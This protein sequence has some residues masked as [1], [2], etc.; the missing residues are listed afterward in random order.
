MK[1]FLLVLALVLLSLTQVTAQPRR[2]ARQHVPID[3][4]F[5][6]DPCILAD[7][8]THMYYMTGTG[9]MLWRSADLQYWDGP[10]QVTAT[11]PDSWM[12]PRPMIWAAEL[13]AIDG[14]YYYFATF[15][16]REVMIDTVGGTPIERR[17]CHV[18]VSDKPDGPYSSMADPTYLP[19]TK[20]TLDGTYWRDSDGKPY[21]IFCHE[22][23]QNGNG[24]VE[25]IPLKDDLS[26]TIG[27]STILFRAH[28][29]PWSLEK[30]SDDTI[31]PNKVTDGPWL[32]RTD[33]G[34]LGM[35]WT[36][37]R[38]GEYTQGVAYSESGTLD[39]PW[40]HEKEPI[41]PPNFGHAMLFRTFEG[42]WLMS[43]HSH[44]KDANGRTIRKPCLFRVDLSGDKLLVS[45]QYHPGWT[46]ISNGEMW[47]DDQGK[48][49]QAHAAGFLH[50]GDTWYM[51]GE[52]RLRSWNPDVN[53][54][55]SKDLVHWHFES[56][57]IENGVT[58][59]ELGKTRF[60]ERAKLLRSPKTGKYV[61][62]CHWE[63]QGYRAS[64]AACFVADNITGPYRFVS[65][66]RPLNI[67]S[68]DCNVFVDDDGTAWFISTIEE[69]RH[70]GLFRLSDDYTKAEECTVLFRE[71]SREAPAI[72][73]VDD[74]YYMLSSA[75]TGWAPNQCKLSTTHTL[76]SGWTPLTNVGDSI[77]FD[78]QAASI[79]TIKGSKK[80]TYLYVGDRWM[81]PGLPESKTIIF[82]IDFHDGT[83]TFHPL[84][85]FE[86]NFET[87]EWRETS[88]TDIQT[89]KRAENMKQV[90]QFIKNCGHYFLATTEGQQPRVRPF[91]TV[92]IFDG[93]L[94]IQTGKVKN[95]A[96]QIARNPQVEICA[97]NGKE[98]IRVSGTLIEDDRREARKSMLDAY[99]ELRSMYSEDDGNTVVY[100]L[101]DATATISSFTA[102]EVKINF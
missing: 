12:G 66:E 2:F 19:A 96:H 6:S 60:I 67:K 58:H 81:D 62:W 27:E 92:N 76:T 83:C 31:G 93:K 15:T 98:W 25:K 48:D 41:T 16:N 52:D 55:S 69:N 88:G 30:Y 33:S 26:G 46:R 14:K 97:F 82:P 28:D 73:R 56:K 90:Y 50:E 47:T 61:V 37:W 57:I 77:A 11:D 64:E 65:G 13:H 32:F 18:L 40:V 21:L 45:E 3:S 72:V 79:L 89:I 68:R 70:L 59:P 4:I 84:D 51:I 5:L 23:L 7:S 34:R 75:C 9:G 99:P 38:F 49:V 29:S 36:S 78:T 80:T 85:A 91:G 42:E 102:P 53:M 44:A 24:T 94:Y 20:P 35:M 86:I 8:V 39:G 100:Y 63:G 1:R 101:R 54:Y 95:V 71:Q 87:G 10:Y 17:A 43:V 74:M 22:W